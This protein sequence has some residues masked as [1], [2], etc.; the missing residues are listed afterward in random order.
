[1]EK[2]T[3]E[4]NYSVE[5]IDQWNERLRC[6]DPDGKLTVSVHLKS[7]DW[8]KQ[9]VDH[10]RKIFYDRIDE[11][12]DVFVHSEEDETIRPTNILAFMDEIHK[13]RRKVGTERLADYNIGFVR[14]ENQISRSDRRRVVW[15]FKWEDEIENT[16]DHPDIKGEYFSTPGKKHHQGMYMAVRDQ[17]IAWKTRGPECLFDKPVRRYGYHRE[18]VSGAIDLYDEHYCNVT[19]LIPLDSMEDLYVHHLPNKNNM[20]QPQQIIATMDLHKRR[21]KKIMDGDRYK[22]LWVDENGEYDGIHMFVDESNSSLSL[23]Y[24]LDLYEKY[25]TRGGMLSDEELKEWDWEEKEQE[26]EA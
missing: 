3:L 21:M 8:G 2:K 20:K 14:Y 4:N 6:R 15:E 13:L 12:Y 18:R 25:V 10:H 9:M 17:L 19:Q 11:G 22:K 26:K 24:D 7:P 5:K 1:M 16:I 23:S